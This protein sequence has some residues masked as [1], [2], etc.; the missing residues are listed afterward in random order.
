MYGKG[1]L[2]WW[3]Q[4]KCSSRVSRRLDVHLISGGHVGLWPS[5]QCRG[6][7]KDESV[8]LIWRFWLPFMPPFDVR[9]F[10]QRRGIFMSSLWTCMTS[11]WRPGDEGWG[12]NKIQQSSQDLRSKPQ[13]LQVSQI[14]C[15]QKPKGNQLHSLCNKRQF[16]WHIQPLSK[17]PMVL[18]GQEADSRTGRSRGLM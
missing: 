1:V 7:S 2:L 4:A 17:L 8:S 14:A 6:C 11:H 12:K 18:W 5:W 9:V 10:S 13:V 16:Q 3:G 15:S